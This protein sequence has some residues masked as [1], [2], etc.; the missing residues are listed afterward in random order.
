MSNLVW[1]ELDEDVRAMIRS[2]NA[3]ANWRVDWTDEMQSKWV[4]IYSPDE[5][6]LCQ[7]L[8]W[9]SQNHDDKLLFHAGGFVQLIEYFG[10]RT[11]KFWLTSRYANK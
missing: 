9:A 4:L 3:R 5:D 6:I 7:K 11:L 1:E 2:I 8:S 10:S